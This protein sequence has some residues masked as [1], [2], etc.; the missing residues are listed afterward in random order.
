MR[1]SIRS[2]SCPDQE[3]TNKPLLASAYSR[4]K[5]AAF[6]MKGYVS[7]TMLGKNVT[8]TLAVLVCYGLL[9]SGED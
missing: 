7:M 4:A 6:G 8:A 9:A 3:S 1:I 2:S 5:T